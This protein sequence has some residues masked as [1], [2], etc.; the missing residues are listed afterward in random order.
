MSI[1]NLQMPGGGKFRS[2]VTDMKKDFPTFDEMVLQQQQEKAKKLT[3][4]LSPIRDQKV[5]SVKPKFKM[6]SFD[7]PDYSNNEN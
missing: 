7:Q 6:P 1:D 4:N 5:I 3:K 2:F